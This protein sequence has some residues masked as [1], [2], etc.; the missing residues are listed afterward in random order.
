MELLS[1]LTASEMILV[2][3]ASYLFVDWL[4]RSNKY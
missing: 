4:L 2:V 3:S 1:Q